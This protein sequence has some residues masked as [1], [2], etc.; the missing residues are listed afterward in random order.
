MQQRAD[1]GPRL[2]PFFS[3]VSS[4]LPCSGVALHRLDNDGWGF[5]SNCFVCE[6]TNEGGLRIPYFHDDESE[7]VVADFI[8]DATFS[9]PPQYVHGGVTLAILDEAMAW[10]TIALARSF[11]LTRTTT[12]TFRR[13]VRIGHRHR[14][15]ARMTGRNCD[16]SI[17]MAGV[18]LDGEA[19]TCVEATAEFVPMTDGQAGSAIGDL[20]GTGARFVKG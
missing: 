15:E 16:G 9:G 10:A 20:G 17:D 18:V 2:H 11:S 12:S 14:V 13:P 6:P 3:R 19:R 5:A 4:P 8:L 1:K 7:L